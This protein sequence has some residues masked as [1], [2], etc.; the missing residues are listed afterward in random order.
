M[1]INR[2]WRERARR[3]T[4]SRARLNTQ[5]ESIH[6]DSVPAVLPYMMTGVRLSWVRW[7]VISRGMLTGPASGSAWV[8][9]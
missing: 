1:I 2:T 3:I 7:I 5:M 8:G 9:R 6:E 4:S